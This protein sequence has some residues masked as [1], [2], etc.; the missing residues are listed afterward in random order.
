MD[1][2]ALV[3]EIEAALAAAV[4]EDWLER[5]DQPGLRWDGS[6][7]ATVVLWLAARIGER[8]PEIPVPTAVFV[9]HGM[10]FEAV[11]DFVEAVA[12]AWDVPLV[13]ARDDALA[14]EAGPEATVP[15]SSL[16]PDSRRRLDDADIADDTL[17]LDPRTPSGRHLLQTAPLRDAIAD[18]GLDAV[19]EGRI[20]P[21]GTDP[22]D[23]EVVD[24]RREPVRV[25]PLAHLTE[26]DVWRIAIEAD[27]PVNPVY[28]RGHRT[29]RSRLHADRPGDEPAW[30]QVLEGDDEGEAGE[31]EDDESSRPGDDGPS[32]MDRLREAGS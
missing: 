19:F 26:H 8:R 24:R 18:E 21:D 11:P 23:R 27:L 4:V 20:S 3:D 13:V 29:V 12:D 9:D 16:D 15:V 2:A 22:D 25:Y 31:T 17:S 1:Y 30:E 5:A 10:H 14:P 7:G 6:I 28:G 32:L